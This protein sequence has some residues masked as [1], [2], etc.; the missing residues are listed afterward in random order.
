MV[1]K[2]DA[3]SCAK[4]L[5]RTIFFL[6]L[7]LSNQVS[8]TDIDVCLSLAKEARQTK[9]GLARFAVEEVADERVG[10]EG[11]FIYVDVDIDG[12]GKADSLSHDCPRGGSAEIVDPCT[13]TL[14][15]SSSNREYRLTADRIYLIKFVDSFYVVSLSIGRERLISI[16]R[17]TA[18]ES[19][20]EF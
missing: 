9:L 14:V 10:H 15:A 20:C 4:K 7:L 1:G 12:D 6:V 11:E 2:L 3:P 8:A 19:I 5:S 17:G 18:M 16:R 13:L